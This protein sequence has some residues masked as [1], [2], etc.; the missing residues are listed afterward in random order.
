PLP[1]F[2]HR[3]KSQNFPVYEEAKR[4]GNMLQTRIRK[5]EGNADALRE[6]LMAQL[7]LEKDRIFVNH[8]TRHVI[9]KG[10]WKKKVE[11]FLSEQ[12]F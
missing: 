12:K 1:Y 8:L 6:Q 9:I 5:V 10:H 4:G 2:V 3:S 11:K 7:N